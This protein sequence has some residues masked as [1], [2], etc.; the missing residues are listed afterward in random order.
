MTCIDTQIDNEVL[1]VNDSI[2]SSDLLANILGKAGFTVRCAGSGELAMKS[3]E[4]NLPVLILLSTKLPDIDGF[5]VCRSLKANASTSYIPVIFIGSIVDE[6]SKAKCYLAGG[7]DCIDQPLQAEEVIAKVKTHIELIQLRSNLAKQGTT[8]ANE[9]LMRRSAEEFSQQTVNELSLIFNNMLNAFVIW[10]SVFDENGNYVSFRFG[11]FNEAYSRIA[12]VK[13]EDVRGRDVFEVWPTTEPEWVEVYGKVAVTGLPHTFDMYHDPTNGWYHCNAYRPTDSTARVCVIFDDITERKLA[14]E[15]LKESEEKFRVLFDHSAVGNSMT[16]LDGT[17]LVNKTFCNMIGYSEE[18]LKIK[19]WADITH[20]DDIQQSSN[21]MKSLI[22]GEISVA[23]FEKRYIHKNGSIVWTD[24]SSYL[25][26]DKTGDP[27][28][29]ITTINDIT[30]RK[31]A[32]NELHDSLA[33]LDSAQELAKIGFWSLDLISMKLEWSKGLKSIF[34]FPEGSPSPTYEEFWSFV[35]E[36]DKEFIEE[37]VCKQLKPLTET[38]ITYTYRITTV[39]GN[40]KHLE[41]IGRQSINNEGQVI[42]IFGSVQDITERKLSEEALK[43][44]QA[45]YSDLVETVQDLIWQC[46]I[47]GRYSY[48]NPAWQDVLGYRIEEMLGRKF[49]DFQSPDR[50]IKD[51]EEFGHLLDGNITK[52]FETVHLTK[53]GKEVNLVFNAKC[54][55]DFK[56]KIT[57]I[58]GSAYNITKRK[59]VEDALRKSEVKYRELVEQINDVIFSLDLNGRFTYIS[60]TSEA[61]SGYK[62]EDMVG[63]YLIE[64]LHPQ[65]IEIVIKRFN[66]VISGKLEPMEFQV[67]TTSGEFIWVRSSS[68]PIIEAGKTVGLRGV[69]TDITERKKAEESLLLFNHSI[70][71]ISESLTIT[72]LNNNILFVNQSFLDV[73]G[74]SEEEIIGKSIYMVRLNPPPKSDSIIDD[75][76][77]G[78]WQGE[79]LN[80]KKDG[81]VFPIY[82]TTSVVNDE[83]GNPIALVGISTDISERKQA[84]EALRESEA[85]YRFLAENSADNIWIRDLSLNYTYISPSIVRLIGYTAEEEMSRSIDMCYTPETIQRIKQLYS[86]EME[87]EATGTADP[88]R[89]KTIEMETYKK[90]GSIVFLEASMS[91]LRDEN[92][93]PFGILGVTRDITERKQVQEKLLESE[94]RYRKIFNNSVEGIYQTT[95]NGRYRTINPAFARMYGF[96]TP[97]EMIEGITNI[98]EQIY[99]NPEDRVRLMNMLRESGGMVK[100]FEVQL[101][102]RDGSLFWVSINALLVRDDNGDLSYIEGTCIDITERKRSELA[103]KI[104]KE[105]IEESEEKHRFLFENTIQG[106]VYQDANDKIIY[107]NKAAER[108]LGLTFDQMEGLSSIDPRWKS[109]HEDGTNFPGE[110][111][112]STIT[113]RTGQPVK[114]TVMGVFN[115]LTNSYTWININSIPKFKDNGNNPYQVITTFEDITE[116]K[117][118]TEEL[119]RIN[120]LLEQSFEQSPVPMVL[121]SMP[122]AVF[123][124][125]NPACREFLGIVDEPSNV[126]KSLYGY[127]SSYQEYDLNNNLINIEDS[128]LAHSLAGE[129]TSNEERMIVRKD[130]SIRWE[131]VSG[132]PI[133]NS[134]NEI[135]AGYLIMNDVTKM[136]LIEK[137]LIGAK[138]KAEESDRLKSAFLANMSHEI[139][140]PMNGIL[141]FAGLL[142]QPDLSGEEQREYLTIIEKSGKR[143]LNIINDLIDISKVESGQMKT[144]ISETNIN[145]LIEEIYT[146]FKPEFEKKGMQLYFKIS[147]PKRKATILSDKEKIFAILTNLVKN[148]IKYS[149]KGLVEFG[150]E[151][152]GINL[153]FFVKDTGIGIAKDKLDAIF[154]RFVQAELP[155]KSNYEGAG[156]GLSIAKAYVEMLGGTIRVE[157]ELGFGTKFIFTIPYITASGSNKTT[158]NQSAMP[159]ERHTITGLKILIAE[160]DDM[161]DKLISLIINKIS[162]QV[163]HVKTGIDAIETCRKNPDIDLILMDI[164]MPQMNGYEATKEIRRFNTDVI[165]IAQTAYA[166]TGDRDKAIEA[167]C[168]GYIS[169]PIDNEE[170]LELIR[171]HRRE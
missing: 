162:Q 74:Y 159:D 39:N 90:D 11:Q 1:I 110:D 82:L 101:I 84:I 34:E 54:I 58:S 66:K 130:N 112:P 120:T 19:N 129:K 134:K 139:R 165:I 73:Y 87:L 38:E 25:Q 150:Y 36:N 156:L 30:D 17:I 141:G 10:E 57:G 51:L 3:I 28:F 160:D 42:E 60:P 135:I 152:N 155:L 79:L 40:I 136:K 118:A 171:K 154:E 106:V 20:P 15:L 55:R 12:K 43:N 167:G 89:I 67:K 107:A 69:L 170:L 147:L 143:M 85:K 111:H 13:L 102:H 142:K 158:G 44:S 16:G 86:E 168:N 99:V 104:A 109:I 98:G 9:T 114:N 122:D 6:T 128:P 56:G 131:L 63:H 48:L 108:I 2:D 70:K 153:E 115:P 45:L 5:E 49:T 71:S 148:A 157:S 117:K 53:D 41:H 169:K 80:R 24:I 166:L 64:F 125:I 68:K 52:G 105:R 123:R 149:Q 161:A 75:T 163:L 26:R 113:L 77:L 23:R 164:K 18:E 29:F 140:T 8:L 7:I 46:D 145:D 88:N 93:V 132:V 96:D 116:I 100:N 81:T 47:E 127:K 151:K 22:E 31:R 83:H 119:S 50:A 59:L 72:D 35:Y 103:L 14:T 138:E 133:Y 137:E 95:A 126:G 37:M 144:Y 121:V 76:L 62:P 27:Q 78:G 4:D 65:D 146:F 91:F 32:E 97:E 124:I 61:I 94:E 92:S 21:I 33:K